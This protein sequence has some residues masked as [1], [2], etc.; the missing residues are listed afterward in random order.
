[1]C[2]RVSKG[3]PRGSNIPLPVCLD[4]KPQHQDDQHQEQEQDNVKKEDQDEG[5]GHGQAQSQTQDEDQGQGQA[6]SQTQDEDQGQAQ[7]Q[8]DSKSSNGSFDIWLLCTDCRKTHFDDN[9]EAI[10]DKALGRKRAIREKSK[11]V[12]KSCAVRVYGLT[13]F[14]LSALSYQ[15][16]R[17]P[18]YRYGWPMRLYDRIKV[19]NLALGIHAGWIGVAAVQYGLARKRQALFKERSAADRVEKRKGSDAEAGAGLDAEGSSHEQQ[20]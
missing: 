9:P 18:Y 7:P 17:N 1:G 12:T 6:Q 14:D 5:Q 10:S 3:R 11:R 16:R 4:K 15:A 8:H 2:F 20:E 19:Q 13:E